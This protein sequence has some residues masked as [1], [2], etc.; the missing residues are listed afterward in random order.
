MRGTGLD[1]AGCIAPLIEGPKPARRRSNECIQL[2]KMRPSTPEAT[3]TTMPTQNQTLFTVRSTPD[4]LAAQRRDLQGL[5]GLD[6]IEHHL[7]DGVAVAE[8][9][10]LMALV[11]SR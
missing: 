1:A 10:E 3:R 7:P 2:E 5:R 9:M 4:L 6:V 8:F 11:S